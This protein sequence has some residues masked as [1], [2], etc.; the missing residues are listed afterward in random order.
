MSSA[1]PSAAV[2]ALLFCAAAIALSRFEIALVSL[3]LIVCVA[4]AWQRR[5]TDNDASVITA[6][7]AGQTDDAKLRYDIRIDPPDHGDLAQL[8]IVILDNP[9]GE[10]T[11][12]ARGATVPGTVPIVHSGPQDLLGI[13]YRLIGEDAAFVSEPPAPITVRR[14]VSPS[15]SPVSSLPLPPVL[16]GLTGTHVSTRPGDGG[17]FRDI[18]PF[19]PG[20][21]LRRIDWKATARRAQ[22]PGELYVRRTTATA[23]AAVLLVVDS[24]DDVGENIASWNQTSSALQGLSSMDVARTAASSLA[25]GYIKAGDRVGFQDLASSDRVIQHGGGSRHLSRVLRAIELTGPSGPVLHRVRAPLVVPGV[26][27]Y[28]FSTFLDDEAGRMAVLWR[29]A[30]HRVIAV[31]VLP[32]ARAGRLP[33]EQVLAHRIIMM[34]RADRIRGLS[35]YGIDV[36]AWNDSDHDAT[37]TAMLRTLS[38]PVAVRR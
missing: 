11:V 20:D 33:R 30:G 7:L 8:R 4:L 22:T 10:F 32:T 5:P 3:P 25:A 15:Y 9:I 16:H 23:D 37:R 21:R 18:H 31:D 27:I 28:V 14:T 35:G 36:L 1:I 38:L 2:V 6:E 12:D 34:E 29:G 17:E 19:T 24:R 13:H 26:L